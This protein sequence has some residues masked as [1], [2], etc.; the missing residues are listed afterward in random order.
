M[1]KLSSIENGNTTLN[2]FPTNL[3]VFKGENYDRLCIQIRVIFRFQYVLEIVNDDLSSM[4]NNATD[5]QKTTHL[6]SSKKDEKYTFLIHQCVDSKI[7]NKIIKEEMA[8]G[9]YTQETIW[10]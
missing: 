2:Q 4:E 8:K 9:G 6:E 10:W 1:I 3:L 5:V 7:F